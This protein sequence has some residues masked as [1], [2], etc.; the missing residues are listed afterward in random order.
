MKVLVVYRDDVVRQAMIKQLRDKHVLPPPGLG[1]LPDNLKYAVIRFTPKSLVVGK[2][3]EEKWQ[4]GHLEYDQPQ[5]CLNA[6]QND[7]HP[8]PYNAYASATSIIV[9]TN[10]DSTITGLFPD[11]FPLWKKSLSAMLDWIKECAFL[12]DGPRPHDGGDVNH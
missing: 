9:E 4:V 12:V 7:I 3:S 2:P 8:T 6:F 11:T 1:A 10:P 5:E